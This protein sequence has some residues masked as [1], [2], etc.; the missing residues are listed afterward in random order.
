MFEGCRLT[1][2][3][4]ERGVG[5]EVEALPVLVVGLHTE[6][7]SLLYGPHSDVGHLRGY[8]VAAVDLRG[9]GS[10]CPGDSSE[11]VP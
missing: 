7:T 3:F 10:Q 8:V 2:E 6:L 4:P 1:G 5:L 9:G 11:V